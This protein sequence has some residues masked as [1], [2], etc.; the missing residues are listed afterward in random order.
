MLDTELCAGVLVCMH[1]CGGEGEGACVF[2]GVTEVFV[3]N[4]LILV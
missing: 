1:V 3:F 4:E 2:E